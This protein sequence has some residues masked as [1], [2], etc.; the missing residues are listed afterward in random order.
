MK[1]FDE[2]NTILRS[3]LNYTFTDY[4]GNSLKVVPTHRDLLITAPFIMGVM[5]MKI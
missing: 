5:N 1:D 4:L 2:R 3:K